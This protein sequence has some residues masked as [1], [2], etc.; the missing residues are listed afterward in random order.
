MTDAEPF[1]PVLRRTISEQIRDQLLK[2]IETGDLAPGARVPSERDLCAQFQVA[3]TSVR[4]AMQG[5]SSLGVIVRRGNRSYVAELVPEFRVGGHGD[6]R[7]DHVRELFETRRALELPI[8]ELAATRACGDDLNRVEALAEKFRTTMGLS[9]F[10]KLDREFHTA[11]TS[12]CGNAM[13]VELHGKVLDALFR[14]EAFDSLL[15]ASANRAEV[16]AI[17]E[18]ASADHIA[19]AEAFVARDIERVSSTLGAHL[20][21]V[22]RRMLDK[23]V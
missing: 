22:E 20:D 21:E 18:H 3:R 8:F 10:R 6:E 11:I 7:K 13:L 1:Q 4:E 2:R 15:Y 23:L 14:S 9:D 17:V 16:A 12:M 5:L 19:I